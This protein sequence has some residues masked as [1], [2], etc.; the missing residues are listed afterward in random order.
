MYKIRLVVYRCFKVTMPINAS[1]CK[2]TF[3]LAETCLLNGKSCATH[4]TAHNQFKQRY[5]KVNLIREKIICEDNDIYSSG[6]AYSILN[7][8]LYLIERYFGR[9]T[10]IWCSKIDEIDFD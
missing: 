6:G 5:P 7:F 8:I 4:R 9:E 2:G 10:A 3:L 1:L